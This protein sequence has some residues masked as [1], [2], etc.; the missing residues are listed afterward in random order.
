MSLVK[1][2]QTYTLPTQTEQRS[3]SRL[4][5]VNHNQADEVSLLIDGIPIPATLSDLSAKGAGITITSNTVFQ[6]NWLPG[7]RG[8]LQLPQLADPLPV[9]IRSLTWQDQAYLGKLRIGLRFCQ[10]PKPMQARNFTRFPLLGMHPISL[11]APHPFLSGERLS[12]EV[13][14]LSRGGLSFVVVNDRMV[15]PPHTRLD[16]SLAVVGCV[17]IAY[18]LEIKYCRLQHGKRI[19]GCAFSGEH[20][21]QLDQLLRNLLANTSLITHKNLIQKCFQLSETESE[22]AKNQ[23]SWLQSIQRLLAGHKR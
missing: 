2:T 7:M 13:C 22:D 9:V 1:K 4:Q 19:Y 3:E 15:L 14:E 16:A 23:Q 21:N 20:S 12:A 6:P 11:Q 5:I 8:L 17:P 10:Q 18:H